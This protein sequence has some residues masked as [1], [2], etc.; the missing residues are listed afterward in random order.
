VSEIIEPRLSETFELAADQLEKAGFTGLPA[1][2]VLCGGTAQLAGIRRLGAEILR[3]PVRVGD[4]RSGVYGLTDQVAT[5]AFATS[6]GLLKWG[7]EQEFEPGAPRRGMP[8][9]GIGS[10]LTSWLRNFLP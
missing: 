1:G 3:G 10:A 7:L 8:L 5:P 9:S 6:I 2:F 4:P